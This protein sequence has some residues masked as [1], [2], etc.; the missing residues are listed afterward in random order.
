MQEENI[1]NFINSYFESNEYF[2]ITMINHQ[3]IITMYIHS[4]EIY[5]KFYM[6]IMKIVYILQLIVSKMKRIAF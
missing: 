3:T 4:K 5:Q 2:F 6:Q 1:M